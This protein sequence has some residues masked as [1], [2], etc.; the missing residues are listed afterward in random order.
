M[1]SK[2]AIRRKACTGK[3]RHANLTDAMA[4]RAHY[5]KKFGGTMSAYHCSFCGGYHIGHRPGGNF[6]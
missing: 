6:K 1:S 3:V 5:Q 4:H 2:R